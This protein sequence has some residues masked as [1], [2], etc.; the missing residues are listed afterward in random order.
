MAV[1]EFFRFDPVPVRARHNG[2][3]PALQRRFILLLSQGAGPGEAARTCGK[4]KQTAYALRSKA[5]G[6]GFA[7]AWD[8][9]VDFAAAAREAA[10]PQAL[11]LTSCG[12]ETMMVPRFYRGRLV[13]F[14][15]RE[16]HHRTLRIV[17]QLDKVAE[18]VDRSG[19]DPALYY[20]ALEAFD[21]LR[22]VETD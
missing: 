22:G 17:K 6:Q 16:D 20:D 19:H 13:G 8:M 15:A 12:M 11:L 9:A 1:P 3:A 18:R 21:R 5:A 7:A 10:R 14:A 2:W 4:S